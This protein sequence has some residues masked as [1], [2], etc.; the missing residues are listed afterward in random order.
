MHGD[1]KLHDRTI[2]FAIGDAFER[3]VAYHL[4]GRIHN[5][6]PPAALNFMELETEPV[7]NAVRHREF[8]VVLSGTLIDHTRFG[9][10]AVHDERVARWAHPFKGKAGLRREH[11]TG[12]ETSPIFGQVDEMHLDLTAVIVEM[13]NDLGVELEA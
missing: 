4:S 2:R 3:E 6:V 1:W 5:F 8:D 11:N 10:M 12:S 7:T 9:D 13:Y